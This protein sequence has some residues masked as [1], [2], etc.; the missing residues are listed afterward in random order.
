ME[1]VKNNYFLF[2]LILSHVTSNYGCQLQRKLWRIV[3]QN[4]WSNTRHYH[5]WNSLWIINCVLNQPFLY[6]WEGLSCWSYPKISPETT[7][8]WSTLSVQVIWITL[9]IWGKLEY[10]GWRGEGET[11]VEN[12]VSYQMINILVLDISP[13]IV[14]A[15]LV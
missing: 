8:F 9:I 5:Y 14:S 7:K 2:A 13:F 12:F 15:T 3:S 1:Q 11:F 10:M 6:C 4:K